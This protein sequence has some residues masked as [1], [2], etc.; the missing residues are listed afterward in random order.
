MTFKNLASLSMIAL[1]MMATSCNDS[2]NNGP[3]LKGH[4]DGPVSE[5]TAA[6]S[7]TG[8]V[9][10]TQYIKIEADSLGNF[11]FNPEF[12][13][14]ITESTVEFY[15]GNATAGAFLEKGAT[16][17]LNLTVNENGT[18]NA[19]YAGDNAD[20]SRYVG[21][22][23][24]VFNIMRYFS[25]EE[26]DTT[27]N[28][29]YRAL[30]D[31]EYENL[32]PVIADIKNSKRRDYFG[33]YAK[34]KYDWQRA[35]LIMDKAY[36][37]GKEN[38]DYPEY[39]EIASQV[40]PNDELAVRTSLYHVWIGQNN[41]VKS[42]F[43]SSA[44]DGN[45][46][47]LELIANNITNKA[48]R[49][50][51]FNANANSY[52]TYSTPNA[53]QVKE[54]FD[55]YKKYAAEYPELIAKYEPQ[56]KMLMEKVQA[57]DKLPYLPKLDTPDGQTVEM[58]D[59]LGK[60]LYIDVWA[61]WCGPCQKEIPNFAAAQKR[62]AGNKNIEFISISVDEDRDAWVAQLKRENPAWRQFRLTPEENQQFS[63]AL[64][65]NGIPRFILVAPDGTLIAPDAARPS[66]SNIDEIL[67]AAINK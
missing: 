34:G 10:E 56:V 65:I 67:N 60:V 53:A 59:L 50:A 32:K 29:Q 2:K 62:F 37:E 33:R 41:P 58:K 4:I 22:A 35:R 1:A 16:A 18:V 19:E 49:R 42:E 8:D 17:E 31:S 57:G 28:E 3:L 6:F 51:A 24:N 9:I 43:G 55:A 5:L 13:E 61:T 25:L 54:Y 52:L 20:V 64:A 47:E 26:N 44:P 21:E 66:D 27:T 40:D 38:T 46:S 30:L 45:I 11:E 7:P 63:K 39:V 12:P 48:N 23:A 36:R 15:V 14:G